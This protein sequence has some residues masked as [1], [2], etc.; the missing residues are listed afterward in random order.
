MAG[1]EV[2]RS[3]SGYGPAI[4]GDQWTGAGRRGRRAPPGCQRLPDTGQ[5][6]A[7]DV[8]LAV[9]L[10]RPGVSVVNGT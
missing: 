3:C 10:V 7:V 2:S 8:E 9:D 6:P 5:L 4:S 1:A